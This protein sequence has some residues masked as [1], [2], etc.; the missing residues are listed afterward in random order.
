MKKTVL[1]LLLAAAPMMGQ[2]ESIDFGADIGEYTK[3]GECDDPRFHGPGMAKDLLAE[4]IGKDATDCRN[5]MRDG[6]IELWIEAKARAATDCSAIEFG[7]DSSTYARDGS[8]D[9]FRF[10]GPGAFEDMLSEDIRR[11]ASDCRQLCEA[12]KVFLR[13]Y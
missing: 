8:C 6:R 5:A 4:D 1:C 2:A 10:K 3:D 7:D 13:D 11:D 9:D 12:G